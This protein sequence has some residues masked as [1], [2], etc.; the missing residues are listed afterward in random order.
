[1]VFDF[2]DMIKIVT[3]VLFLLFVLFLLA[4]GKNRRLSQKVFA[5]F[6]V[7]QSFRLL[8]SLRLSL[9]PSSSGHW[10][11]FF[12]LGRTINYLCGPSLYFYA[13]SV[14][15]SGFHFK[16]RHWVHL[17]P[18]MLYFLYMACRFHFRRV[19]QGGVPTPLEN[20]VLLLVFYIVLTAYI[21]SA[22]RVLRIYN[23]EIKQTCSSVEK[24][25]LNWLRFVLI[26]V[27]FV[28]IL[29]ILFFSASLLGIHLRP[30]LSLVYAIIFILVA[31]G[32]YRILNQPALFV[33]P[34]KYKQS[35]LSEAD[36]KSILNQLLVY[37]QKEKPYLNPTLTLKDLAETIRFPPRA[38]S[39]VINEFLGKNFYD[40]IN[41]HRIEEAKRLLTDPVSG[42]KTVLEILYQAGYN[43]KSSFNLAFKQHTGMTPLEFKEKH[44]RTI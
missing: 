40:F 34:E 17:S 28:V 12:L 14:T 21:V 36:K 25:N 39:Q 26:G 37:I 24:I 2:T 22:L 19:S 27:V 23:S 7:S 13:R 30:L 29:E 35:A 6:L 18:L 20:G 15:D 38:V 16:R 42:T 32:I 4:P 9:I 44:Q 33:Q 41:A 43:S 11:Y 8:E 31:V 1:M 10:R 5:V 3:L